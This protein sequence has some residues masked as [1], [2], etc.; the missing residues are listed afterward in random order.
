M[1]QANP[2]TLVLVGVGGYG[3]TYVN[4]VLDQKPPLRAVITGVVDPRAEGCKRLAEI[5]ARGLPVY[6]DLETFYAQHRAELAVIS[7]P[8]HLH[9]PQ[10]CLALQQGSNVLCEKP[11]AATIQEVARM[12]AATA[13]S[14][15]FAAIG[16]Q[17]SF[18]PAVQALKA[19]ILAGRLGAPKRLRTLVLWPRNE[20]YYRRN[21]WAG[22]LQN[23]HGDWVLDSPVNN[24]TAHYLHNMFYILGASPGE[25]A[26][27]V[28]LTAE[29]YR[30]NPI[31]NYDTGVVRAWTAAGVEVLFYTTHTTAQLRGPEFIYEFERATVRYDASTKQ[32]TATSTD[33]GEHVYGTPDSDVARKLWD[34]VAAT[35]GGGPIACDVAAAAAQTL[36]MNGMQDSAPRI[37]GFPAD[38]VS[39]Q[40]EEGTRVTVVRDLDIVLIQAYEA[41]R[42]P[43]EMG[44]AWAV[45]GRELEL[46]SY[47]RFPRS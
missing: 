4:A 47:N 13:Q 14:G 7:S 18:S 32:I 39:R 5:R 8:I 42:L 24:A 2:V 41:G 35:R 15:R 37:A 29:L 30:A 23:A 34:C 44:V 17:W 3:H 46:R 9:C 20:A 33:S 36:C 19:D 10:T 6:A 1:N 28:R 26:M 22:A 25:S 27:P 12:R 38:L 21:T 31:S 11:A 16:Y 43:A 40:G 45:A